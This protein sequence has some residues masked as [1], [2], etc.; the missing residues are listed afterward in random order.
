MTPADP[1]RALAANHARLPRQLLAVALALAVSLLLSWLC[2]EWD[3]PD[4]VWYFGPADQE[5]LTKKFWLGFEAARLLIPGFL[6]GALKLPRPLWTG[7]V[8]TVVTFL[9]ACAF[10]AFHY[11]QTPAW[12]PWLAVLLAHGVFGAVAAWVG[13]WAAGPEVP[14][15]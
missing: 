2:H 5:P 1:D 12:G 4:A 10:V 14:R 11:G 9:A 15:P 8:V 13:R 7:A 6:V 3:R